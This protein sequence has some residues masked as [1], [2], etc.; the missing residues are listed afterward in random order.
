MQGIDSKMLIKVFR[1]SDFELILSTYYSRNDDARMVEAASRIEFGLDN[2]Y[3]RQR[4][5]PD[6]DLES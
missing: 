2:E 4:Y 1:H 5:V 6:D 3:D